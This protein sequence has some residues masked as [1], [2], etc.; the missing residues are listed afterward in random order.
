MKIS[1]IGLGGI[2]QKYYLPILATRPE[3]ELQLSARHMERLQSLQAAYKIESAAISVS[4]VI[5][6]KPDAV[7]VLTPSS[8]HYEIVKALLEQDIDVFVEKPA[9]L[10]STETHA[11]AALAEKRERVLMVGF[12]R[13]YTPINQRAREYWGN[14]KVEQASFIK[15]RTKPI[16]DSVRNH[17]Y[18]D[19]I[20]LVD[21][22]R[23]FCGEGKVT[24]TQLRIGEQF[25]GAAVQ[26]SLES[27]GLAQIATSMRAGQWR[28][29]YTL[30]GDGLTMDIK[31]FKELTISQGDEQR[32]WMESYDSGSDTATG[33]GFVAEIDHFMDCV[34]YRKIPRTDA[35]DSIKTQQMVEAIAG[36]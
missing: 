32:S 9:T 36:E 30:A 11:L 35:W 22:L 18:D 7:F 28:E 34:T 1:V 14:R 20:H 25:L 21:T 33:R 26:V 24:H 6:W 31:A 13:R 15:F 12:N 23:Y 2:S 19:T 10:H 5:Q 27:G 17:L 29:E 4:E 8:T 16:H 3:I